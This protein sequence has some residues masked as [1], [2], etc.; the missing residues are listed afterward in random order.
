MV[1]TAGDTAVTY[2]GVWCARAASGPSRLDPDQFITHTD[3]DGYTVDIVEWSSYFIGV[4]EVRNFNYIS[5]IPP[6]Q[7]MRASLGTAGSRGRT[8]ET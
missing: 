4:T 5:P 1:V 8:S 7:P 6:G 2:F 3:P